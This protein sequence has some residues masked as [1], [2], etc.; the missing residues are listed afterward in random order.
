MNK[1]HW[2]AVAIVAVIWWL[3]EY[4]PGNIMQR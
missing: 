3:Y 4:N 1:Q 2:I